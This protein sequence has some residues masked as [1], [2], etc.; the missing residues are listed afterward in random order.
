M[1][2]GALVGIVGVGLALEWAYWT[3][4]ALGLDLLRALVEPLQPIVGLV[5]SLLGLS[6]TCGIGQQR[7]SWKSVSSYSGGRAR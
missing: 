1:F 3:T 5:P 2:I 4:I 7:V 6:C